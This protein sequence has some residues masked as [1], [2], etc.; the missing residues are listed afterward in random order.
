MSDLKTQIG[1]SQVSDFDTWTFSK[2]DL[3]QPYK[4]DFAII[5][6]QV[7]QEF[8]HAVQGMRNSMNVHP[9]CEPDSEFLDMVSRVDEITKQI[10]L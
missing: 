10:K 5:P 7:F 2:K 1:R 8:L 4:G 6:I 3:F 9:H